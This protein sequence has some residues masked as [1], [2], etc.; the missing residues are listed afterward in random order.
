MSNAPAEF[1][2][3]DIAG[4]MI[5]Q[6]GTVG[7]TA[8]PI[9]SS[10]GNNIAG[11]FIQC[12]PD[13]TPITKRLYLSFDNT[14]WITYK[15]GDADLLPLRGNKTQVYVKGNVASVAY[16]IILYLQP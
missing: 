6:N 15:P 12:D 11:I 3:E 16:Q 9:P 7:L 1:E 14:N 10:A 5:Q 2:I 4:A 13:Q 8:V